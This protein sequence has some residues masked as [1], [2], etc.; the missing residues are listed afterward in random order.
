VDNT[1][2]RQTLAILRPAHGPLAA[3]AGMGKLPVP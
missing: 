2:D 3:V 1:F